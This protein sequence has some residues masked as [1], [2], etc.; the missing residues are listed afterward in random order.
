MPY[1]KVV[2]KRYGKRVF[3]RK[4]KKQAYGKSSRLF[5]AGLNYGIKPDP[6]PARLHT[7]C[8]YIMDLNVNSST[9]QGV[10]GGVTESIRL[11]DIWDPYIGLSGA[12]NTTVVGHSQFVNLY[13]KYIVNGIKLEVQWSDPSADGLVG[14][15]SLNQTATL[16]SQTLR[17]VIEQSLTYTTA[18]NN[19][20]GQ[21][22]RMKFYVT[23][24]SL[25]GLSKLEYKANAQNHSAGVS[26]TP[27]NTVLA[28]FGLCNASS[29]NTEKMRLRVRVIMYTTFFDR[30][31]LTSS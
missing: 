10:V 31:Q 24:W 22:K 28:R 18:I 12:N 16:A 23:P 11:N 21:V 9:T 27:P 25:Q 4:A 2:K 14:I 7:R 6:F 17:S 8:K 13:N 26:A 30:K 3:K 19:T 5:R 15:V 20:G 1:G 29:T